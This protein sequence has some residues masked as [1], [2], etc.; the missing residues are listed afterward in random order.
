MRIYSFLMFMCLMLQLNAQAP[1]T[2]YELEG[3]FSVYFA[4]NSAELDNA[5]LLNIEELL[6][7]CSAS[8]K[9]RLKLQAFTDDLGDQETNEVLASR[10]AAAVQT[11]LLEYGIAPE[12]I[13][14]LASKGMK[15]TEGNKLQE[16]RR[17]HRRVDIEL[18]LA[19][20]TDLKLSENPAISTY[21]QGKALQAFWQKEIEQAT[22]SFSF[23]ARRGAIIEGNAGTVLQI[24]P[25][26]F[27][28]EDGS[29]VEGTIQF[30]LREAYD[31]KAMILQ[32]LST[33]TQGN[34]LET[35]G[36]F[37][38]EAKDANGRNVQIAEGQ[39]IGVIL[40]DQNGL[41]EG[42][43]AYDAVELADGTYDWVERGDAIQNLSIK[44]VFNRKGYRA[45][46]QK[47]T[48][49]A[50]YQQLTQTPF[51]KI[52]LP[53][54]QQ[55]PVFR[56]RTPRKPYKR[57]AEKP[58]YE[59][60]Y[61][62]YSSYK[63]ETNIAYKKRILGYYKR[64]NERYFKNRQYNNK[65]Q[66]A[67]RKDSIA[68]QRGYRKY[69]KD[70]TAYAAY[71]LEMRHIVDRMRSELADFNY[72][73]YMSA[74]E[75]WQ[76]AMDGLEER[77]D[78]LLSLAHNMR[79]EIV[80]YEQAG[81]SF[82]MIA[83]ALDALE[84]EEIKKGEL[85][86]I[87]SLQKWTEHSEKRVERRFKAKKVKVIQRN[88]VII[89][90]EWNV[91]SWLNIMRRRLDYL[92]NSF[93]E[94]GVSLRPY[95]LR[96]IRKVYN[97][98]N[99]RCNFNILIKEGHRLDRMAK[100]SMSTIFSLIEMEICL[101]KLDRE[102]LSERNAKGLLPNEELIERFANNVIGSS[103]SRL[104]AVPSTQL[105]RLG[106]F[107]CDALQDENRVRD[108]EILVDQ[109]NANTAIF[110]LA[111]ETYSVLRG[112]LNKN[113]SAYVIPNV[114]R[115]VEVQVIGIDII[116]GKY[117]NVFI[118]KLNADREKSLR[119]NFERLTF[120]EAKRLMTRV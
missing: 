103:Q 37:F 31:Y 10:R 36:M 97:K 70:S 71:Q 80:T 96:T 109:P 112:R 51:Q 6:D 38:T 39:S 74:W 68:Y 116:D 45:P 34:L 111:G 1:H 2:D 15:I 106:G 105:Y 25:N 95:H 73:D 5:A 46:Y 44:N 54:E 118:E 63:N 120:E 79:A 62:A 42:M 69:Q 64:K 19:S 101:Q 59:M 108:I 91:D 24:A 86:Q 9:L 49:E 52:K 83:A 107:N 61:A 20:E 11:Q 65:K 78:S 14:I 94:D 16:Q 57:K 60:L 87:A 33:T 12:K 90:K 85:R 58:T 4:S 104:S 77:E 81:S 30:S 76:D 26:S 119:P 32:N 100:K 47:E 93:P 82:G 75:T 99:K 102:L 27:T 29:P 55:K 84:L 17:L 56:K 115:N 43:K 35:A 72:M 22:Q 48:I 114:P 66:Y 23:E 21:G 117:A 67:Y 40:A 110:V 89:K 88:R 13:E 7:G 3:Q 98:M 41:K 8:P 50:A 18:W 92:A 113:G 28:Y 53:K